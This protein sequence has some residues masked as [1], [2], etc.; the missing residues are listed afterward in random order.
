MKPEAYPAEMLSKYRKLTEPGSAPATTT[1]S[2]YLG[3]ITATAPSLFTLGIPSRIERV[4]YLR[5]QSV[6]PATIPCL[7][8]LTGMNWWRSC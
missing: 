2:L 7:I 5:C 3:T 1:Q 4:F 6:D 8:R